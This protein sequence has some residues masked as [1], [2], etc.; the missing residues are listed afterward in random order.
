MQRRPLFWFLVSL[1]CLCGAIYFWRLGDK[2][3]A[4]KA[5][6]PVPSSRPEPKPGA[7]LKAQTSPPMKLLTQAAPL[8]P[9][10][11]RANAPAANTRF[12]YRLSNTTLTAGQLAR[13]DK[14]LIL[15]NALIDTE[16]LAGLAIPDRLR[17]AKDSGSYMV[18][19][20]N[21]LDDNFRALLLN[22]TATT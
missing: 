8:N 6:K 15:G 14:A 17:A 21:P 22:A 9:V 4:Q 3:E 20:R 12:P 10:S 7:I 2:W 5:S 11:P 16:K 19:S 13:K 1:A 18:Q